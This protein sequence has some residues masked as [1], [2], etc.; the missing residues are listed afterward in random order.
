LQKDLRF[1]GPDHRRKT[2]NPAVLG[3]IG[4]RPVNA[5]GRVFDNPHRQT[6][7]DEFRGQTNT[8]GGFAAFLKTDNADCF[9]FSLFSNHRIFHRKGAKLA[10]VFVFLIFPETGK[11]KNQPALRGLFSFAYMTTFTPSRAA[12]ERWNKKFLSICGKRIS[13]PLHSP[14]TI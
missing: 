14:F 1:L 7:F 8:Q 4:G 12:Q 13:F 3:G 9:H 11:I 10:K 6:H 2:G 5:F